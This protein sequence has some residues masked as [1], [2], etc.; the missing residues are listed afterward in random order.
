MILSTDV[1]EVR[2]LAPKT[3]EGERSRS[4]KQPVQRPEGRNI[5]GTVRK[6]PEGQYQQSRKSK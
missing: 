4:R 3:V 6:Q 1:C 5:P 2:E